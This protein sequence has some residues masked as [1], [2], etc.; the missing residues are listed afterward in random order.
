MVSCFCP[1]RGCLTAARLSH[2]VASSSSRRRASP[3]KSSAALR[4]FLASASNL[5]LHLLGG[6]T[7]GAISLMNFTDLSRKTDGLFAIFQ[8]FTG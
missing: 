4:R 7:N 3:D 8:V 5:V 6:V 1:M 2:T